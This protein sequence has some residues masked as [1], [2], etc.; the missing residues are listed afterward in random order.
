MF[1]KSRIKYSLEDKELAVRI[2]FEMLI[3]TLYFIACKT[4]E[5]VTVSIFREIFNKT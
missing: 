3:A 5:P 4:F 1:L 2:S